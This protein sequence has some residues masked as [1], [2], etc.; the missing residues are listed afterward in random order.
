MSDSTQEEFPYGCSLPSRILRRTGHEAEKWSTTPWSL[1]NG[2]NGQSSIVL[3]YSRAEGGIP[4]FKTSA[5]TSESNSVEIEVVYSETYEGLDKEDGDG[6]FFLFSN[7]MNTYRRHAHTFNA[8]NKPAYVEEKYAQRSQR[9]QRIILKTPN[10]TI[11]FSSL[12][13]RLLRIPNPTISTFSCSS[14]TLNKI[15]QDGVRTVDMCTVEAGET[16]DA[17]EVTEAGTIIHGQHWAPCRQGTRWGDMK[18]EFEVKIKN[19][20]ASW[21]IHMVAN[22]L[23]FCL[24]SEK[25]SLAAFDGLADTSGVFPSIPKGSWVLDSAINLNEWL[26]VESIAQGTSISITI[27][28]HAVAKVEELNLHPILGGS[29]NNTGSVAFGGPSHYTAL[30]KSLTVKDNA[31]NILYENNLLSANKARTL[32]D[33]QVGTNPLA[34]TIDGAKR[35][36]ACFGGDLFVMGRSIFYSTGNF[37]A[38]LGSIKLL[39]SHQ[40]KDGYLGNLCP[41]QAPIHDDESEPPTYAFY[42]L[43]YALLLIVAIKDYW[44]HSGDLASVQSIWERLEKLI[45]FTE[46]FVDDRGLVVAPPPLSMDWFPMGGPIFGAS[47]KINLAYFDALKAMSAIA[48]AIKVDDPFT[49]KAE[50]LSSSIVAHLWNGETGIMR[51]SD[52]TS[53]TGLCQDINAYGVVTGV[54]PLHPKAVLNLAAPKTSGLPLAFQNIEGW[55]QKKVVSPYASGYA[56]EALFLRGEGSSAVELIERVWG[57]MADT[58]N[59]NYSGGHWEAMQ[60]DGTPITE[61]TSLMHGWSTGPVHLLPR[62]LGGLEPLEA[63]FSRFR[64]KPVLAGL[65]SIDVKLASKVGEIKVSLRIQES[66]GSGN[67]TLK[68]PSGA[69]AEVYAPEGWTLADGASPA[70]K[71][72]FGDDT[73]MI[74]SLRRQSTGA[75]SADKSSVLTTSQEKV[76]SSP[77]L[78]GKGTWLSRLW[79]KILGFFGLVHK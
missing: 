54:S 76:S 42:S 68:I 63:G 55:D 10:S 67:M 73:E 40:T 39:T 48:K 8:S 53:P 28:G 20:G 49:I 26:K 74:L 46:R 79:I 21:G 33:F 56:A 78:N 71:T 70:V 17:W 22:G 9:Y 6:P 1:R 66:T 72:I 65:S 19:G 5:V 60:P 18:V 12:G 64:I 41:I 2:A 51:L 52:L 59:P 32:A 24:D 23:I 3:D 16:A 37:E 34:C 25:R 31:G 14:E 29:G 44:L 69:V 11:S 13:Y 45:A 38:A 58:A 27:N 36:R 30:Y 43:S 57:V 35:D 7:A 77:S 4:F 75:V 15:W 47:G 62:Y 61:D 50:T